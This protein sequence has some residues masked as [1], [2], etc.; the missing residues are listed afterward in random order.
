MTEILAMGFGMALG[1]WLQ[2][3]WWKRRGDSD[4]V[5][6]PI[7]NPTVTAQELHKLVD[8]VKDDQVRASFPVPPQGSW[9]QRYSGPGDRVVQQWRWNGEEAAIDRESAQHAGR[10]VV[11]GTV[12]REWPGSV[13]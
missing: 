3:L 13:V 7:D 11:D 6:P 8:K 1:C 5:P 9:I 12:V 10:L 4:V 2:L